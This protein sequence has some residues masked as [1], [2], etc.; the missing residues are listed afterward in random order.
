[1]QFSHQPAGY[2]CPV[3]RIVAGEDLRDDYT[4]SHTQRVTDYA[5]MLAEELGLPKSDRYDL[6]IGTPLH[7]IG[8]IGISDYILR[9]PGPLTVEEAEYMKSHTLKGAAII[10]IIPHLRAVLP[11]VRS[12]HERWDGLGYPDGLAGSQIPQLGR[13]VCV[14]DDIEDDV[15]GRHRLIPRAAGPTAAEPGSRPRGPRAPRLHRAARGRT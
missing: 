7:D 4:G 3:C 5:L 8:K 14:A 2:R 6:Q 13:I 12:H 10:E 11:I 15:I 9:K 1:M